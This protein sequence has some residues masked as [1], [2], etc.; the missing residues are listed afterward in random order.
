MIKL[1]GLNG[2]KKSVV[3]PPGLFSKVGFLYERLYFRFKR[4]SCAGKGSDEVF[5]KKS[6]FSGYHAA[7][8]ERTLKLAA[9]NF[10]E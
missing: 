7:K 1:L 2:L 4:R 9:T 8:Q 5:P 6:G 3:S 10:T